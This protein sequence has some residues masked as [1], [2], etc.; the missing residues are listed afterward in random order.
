MLNFIIFPTCA[1]AIVS[2]RYEAIHK[3]ETLLYLW[4]NHERSSAKIK[5][6]QQ[7]AESLCKDEKDENA[8]ESLL[9]FRIS[10]GFFG[11][12]VNRKNSETFVYMV[13]PQA[14]IVHYCQ[15][16]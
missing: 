5:V 12:L 1:K 15:P 4:S 7:K 8:Y 16:I 2:I 13:K 3:T 6:I 14:P 9:S 11:K 10:D